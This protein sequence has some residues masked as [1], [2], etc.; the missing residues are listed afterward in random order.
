MPN[1]APGPSG[2]PAGPKTGVNPSLDMQLALAFGPT[3][4]C[5]VSCPVGHETVTLTLASAAR[6]PAMPLLSICISGTMNDEP[7]QAY[8]DW[9]HIDA[10][11]ENLTPGLAAATVSAETKALL[12]EAALAAPLDELERA[13][14]AK[15]QI[16]SI[17]MLKKR[18][19]D[20]TPPNIK[21]LITWGSQLPRTA[22]AS[23][24]QS[25]E[26]QLIRAWSGRV[27]GDPG[28]D[29]ELAV[30]VRV[31]CVSLTAHEVAELAVDDVLVLDET[32]LYNKQCCLVIGERLTALGNINGN[33]LTLTEPLG[34]AESS[35]N[36]KYC[37][38]EPS[39]HERR[40]GRQ[41]APRTKLAVDLARQKIRISQLL[42]ID[43]SRA[44]GLPKSIETGVEVFSGH[45]S[46]GYGN[47]V[48]VGDAIAVRLVRVTGLTGHG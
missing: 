10:C 1:D 41:E 48:R 29:P 46:I 35:W 13:L 12:F 18:H 31:G 17:E 20:W 5:A 39:R 8:V 40:N 37:L 43:L 26:R 24:P 21:F 2:E 4:P 30:T 15:V 47:I 6:M 28:A 32:P 45:Q 3:L 7:F 11:L 33:Q 19:G 27:D 9:A 22:Y 16:N 25:V 36:A 44:I 42:G 38:G 14:D 23:V 34:L